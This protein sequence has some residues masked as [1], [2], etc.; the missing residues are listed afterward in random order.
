MSDFTHSVRTFAKSP[1]FTTTVV[2]TLGLGIGGSTAIFSVVNGVL[3]RPLPYPESERIVSLRPQRAGSVDPAHNPADF[4][5]IQREQQSFTALAAHRGDV[6]DITSDRT[7]PRRLDGAHVTSTFFEVFGVPAALGRTFTAADAATGERLLVISDGAWRQQFGGDPNA[8]GQLV[9]V[10]GQPHLL[11]GVMPPGFQWP[12]TTQAWALAEKAVPPAPVDVEG[13][14]LEQR[15]IGYFQAVGRLRAGVSQEQAEGDV[16]AVARRIGERHA[17]ST[18]RSYRLVQIQE[19][20]V[21]EVRQGL[22]FLLGA[23]GCVLLVACANV[24]G[25]LV[26]RGMGRQREIGVRTALGAPRGRIVRQLLTESVLLSLTGGALGLLLASWGTDALVS[27]IPDN[28]PRLSEV[29]V[30][31]RVATFAVLVSAVTGIL[32]GLAPALQTANVNVIE[33]LRDGGRTVGS[34]ASRR[35]RAALVTA[36][37]ALALVLLVSAGLMINSFVRLRAVDPGYALEQVVVTNVVLP[38]AAYGTTARQSA[39]YKQLVERLQ[40]SPITKTSGVT[41]PRPFTDSAGQATFE[42]DRGA[43]VAERDR[44]RA[45]LGIAS[46]AAFTAL[47]VPLISGRTFTEAD[48]DDAPNVVVVNKA[49]ANRYWP[50][51]DAIGKRLTFDRRASNDKVEWS[52]VVGVVGDTRGRALDAPPEPTVYFSYHQFS[53]PFMA[54]VVRGTQDTG[55][56][57]SEIRTHLRALDPNLP[58]DEVTTLGADASRTAAQPRFR[59]FVLAGFAGISLLLA[60]TGLYGLLSYSVSQRVREIGVRMALG[61]RPGDVLRLVVAEGMR[62]VAIGAAVGVLAALAAGRLVASLLFNVSAS[63]PATYGIVTGVLALVA[64]AACYLPAM[65]AARVNPMSALR[66]D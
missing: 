9:R 14:L 6:I 17:T 40:A 64:L 18:G 62:L 4:L 15:E 35:I 52:T 46:P 44:P 13:D 25:L 61:A 41:F 42:L 30:D 58:M 33:L 21:G 8:L 5:D 60:A 37:V 16:A 24:A 53:L 55:A 54:L 28:I 63:D 23:V 1:G 29:H 22:L 12:S 48:T 20:L 51:E 59:T 11:V 7:E 2:L 49:F 31:L 66:A 56:V 39:F 19:E 3:L 36:E 27:V 38:G 65:R 45:N 34:H 43:A 50:G 26:A 10:N 57:A 47:G 32:F